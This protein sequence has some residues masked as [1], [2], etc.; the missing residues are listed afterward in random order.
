[1]EIN[2]MKLRATLDEGPRCK[3]KWIQTILLGGSFKLVP[4]PLNEGPRP[5][6]GKFMLI[7]HTYFGGK[8]NWFGPKDS[9]TK[10]FLIWKTKNQAKN[11]TTLTRRKTCIFN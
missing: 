5:K 2:V 6:S 3:D 11:Q 4:R 7:W 9:A 10:E 1:M 8:F